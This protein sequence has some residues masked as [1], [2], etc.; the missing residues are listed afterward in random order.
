ML[1]NFI[2][3]TLSASNHIRETITHCAQTLHAL[4]VLRCYG[5]PDDALQTVYRATVVAKLLYACP[6]WSGFITAS[7]RKRVEA[8]LRRSKRCGFCPLDLQPFN[9]LIEAQEDQLFSA[10][11]HNPH[12]LL[13]HLLPPPSAASQNYE[14]RHRNISRMLTLFCEWYITTNTK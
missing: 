13:H 5:L 9:D 14:L 6:A 1:V 11:N 10:I 7:D 2:T 12:H 3:N 4:R 8:F